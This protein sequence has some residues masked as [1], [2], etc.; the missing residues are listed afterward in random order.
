MSDEPASGSGSGPHGPPEWPYE[1]DPGDHFETSVEAYGDIAPLLRVAARCRARARGR[2]LA[3]A[4]ERL[5]VHDPYFCS[6]LA[7][8]LLRGLG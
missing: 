4:E 2:P 1:T 3:G 6:V 5:R 8:E 7:A